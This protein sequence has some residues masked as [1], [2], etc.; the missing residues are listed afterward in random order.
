[1]FQSTKPD[2]TSQLIWLLIIIAAVVLSIAGWYRW[3]TG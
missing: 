1:M 3:S 2:R